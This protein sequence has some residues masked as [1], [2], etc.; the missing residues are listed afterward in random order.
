[1]IPSVY[2]LGGRAVLGRSGL[3][4]HHA[5]AN[6]PAEVEQEEAGGP[7]PHVC[8]IRL[9]EVNFY[10]A[11]ALANWWVQVQCDDF[12]VGIGRYWNTCICC[13]MLHVTWIIVD[14]RS[15]IYVVLQTYSIHLWISL[16]IYMCIY[17]IYILLYYTYITIISNNYILYIYVYIRINP[18]IYNYIYIYTYYM[19]HIYACVRALSAF[20]T[21]GCSGV[22]AELIMQDLVERM[23]DMGWIWMRLAGLWWDVMCFYWISLGFHWDLVAFRGIEW[24]IHGI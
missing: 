8:E 20:I 13:M 4:H 3:A 12:I 1:V 14:V 5:W 23:P 19:Y 2:Y 16:C 6:F 15:H 22:R 10:N 17:I 9:E 24:K 11:R 18:Y 7:I 21:A